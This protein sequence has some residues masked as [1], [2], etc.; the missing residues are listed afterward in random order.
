MFEKGLKSAEDEFGPLGGVGSKSEAER[1]CGSVGAGAGKGRRGSCVK[2]WYNLSIRMNGRFVGSFF[3]LWLAILKIRLIGDDRMNI[4]NSYC[5]ADHGRQSIL[6]ISSYSPNLSDL[7]LEVFL[8]GAS[9][10]KA[11]IFWSYTNCFWRQ[12]IIAVEIPF[13]PYIS[14]YRVGSL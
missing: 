8:S 10:P 12:S 9:I 3:L 13:G 1:C 14:D 11:I 7:I 6:L 2:A 4:M 5:M